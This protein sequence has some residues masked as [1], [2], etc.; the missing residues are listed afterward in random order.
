MTSFSEAVAR[1]EPPALPVVD[2]T[3]GEVLDLANAPHD[4]LVKV[5]LAL[6]E[7]KK[8]FTEWA[9][10]VEDEL[11]RRH[12]DRRAAQVVGDHEVDVDHSATRTWDIDDLSATIGDLMARGLLDPRD[13]SGLIKN[14]LKVDGKKAAALLSR[15]EKD[16]DVV[17]HDQN[18]A[19]VELRR[20]FTW[21]KGRAKVKVTPVATL[22]P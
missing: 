9:K 19:L 3:S 8:A 7:R 14:E 18:E 1:R 2:P 12:G 6:E 22:E 4:Q 10:A 20:C 15:L 11:V 16:A 13:A 21:K 5:F 17:P